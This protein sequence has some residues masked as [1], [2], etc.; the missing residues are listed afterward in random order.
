MKLGPS[1]GLGLWH[2]GF[3]IVTQ[4]LLADDITG[5]SASLISEILTKPRQG[6]KGHT[7]KEERGHRVGVGTCT[8]NFTNARV[9]ITN[10]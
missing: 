6:K 1:L 4:S 10:Y 7:A 5:G 8:Q 2:G 3:N 9:K